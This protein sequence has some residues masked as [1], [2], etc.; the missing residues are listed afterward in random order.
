MVINSDI[1]RRDTVQIIKAIDAQI[2]EIKRDGAGRGIPTEK[3]RDSNGN[4][5]MT[6]L[7]LAKAQ[8][9]NTLVLLQTRPK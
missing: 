5:V 6:P 9:Y 1:L 3:L 2:D 7:L 8:A 4:Y